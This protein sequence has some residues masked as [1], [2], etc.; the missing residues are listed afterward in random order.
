M[1]IKVIAFTVSEKSYNISI[2]FCPRKCTGK[3]RFGEIKRY[4]RDTTQ[5]CEN[6]TPVDTNFQKCAHV[7]P[8]DTKTQ[9]NAVGNTIKS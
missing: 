2:C 1:H 7:T 3:L 5:K 9:Q 4:S 8:F 6:M